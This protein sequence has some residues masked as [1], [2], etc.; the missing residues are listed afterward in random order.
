YARYNLR[1]YRHAWWETIPRTRGE[2]LRAVVMKVRDAT[3]PD[4]LVA[5][6]DDAAI[7]LYTGRRAVSSAP[8]AAAA[9]LHP[10]T[11]TQDAQVLRQILQAYPVTDVIATTRDQ[12]GAADLL[13]SARPPLLA[14][15]DSFPG[16]LI[17]STIRK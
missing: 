2:Q 12:A 3:P 8:L 7:Y 1:G 4:A 14:L 10:L 6:T 15:T 13:V 5:G 9:F 11:V 17:Y 16:G